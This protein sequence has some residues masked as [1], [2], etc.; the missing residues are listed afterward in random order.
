M[1]RDDV[2]LVGAG[3]AHLV[4]L[5]RFAM[6]PLAPQARLTLVVP[7]A[8]E[9]YSGAVPAVMAGRWRR[10]QASVDLAWLA[11]AAGARLV[12]AEAVGLDRT[13]RLLHLGDRPPL[14][15]DWLS[16]CP[17]ADPLLV[18][19]AAEHA[20]PLKPLRRL[21]DAWETAAR[22]GLRVAVVGGGAAG[23][24]A[25]LAAR[26]RGAAVT[27]V[28]PE[29][30]LSSL[31][32]A[33]RLARRALAKAGVTVLKGRATEL[34]PHELLL[35]DGGAVPF[36]LCLWAAG[37]RPPAWLADS[38]LARDEKG[39]FVAEP[40]LRARSE[41]RIFLAGDVAS[42]EGAP[43]PRNG[44]HSVRAGVPLAE[45]LRAAL[46]GRA[47]RP[48]RPQRRHLALLQA[49]D[50]AIA[51][52]GGWAAAGRWAL[53]WKDRIDRNWVESFRALPSMTA[54]PAAEMRCEGCGAK[55][56]AAALSGALARLGGLPGGA[57]DDAAA[58]PRLGAAV[59]S[60]D[61]FRPPTDDPWVAGR[62][63]AAH[64]LGD[65]AAM[66]AEPRA[67]LAVVALPHAGSRVTEEELFQL[68][69]GARSVLG[70]A[71]ARLLGGHSAEA[72]APLI[73]FA[74]TGEGAAA[75]LHRS[76]LRAGQV[77]LLTKPLGTGA[78]L[79]GAMRGPG[80]GRFLA[81]TL[82]AMQEDPMPAARILG[83]HG[84]TAAADVTGFGLAG[85]LLEMLEASACGAELDPWAVRAL[86]GA[87]EALGAGIRSTAYPANLEAV[88]GRLDGCETL[89]QARLD[90]L[91]DPQT[92]GGLLAGLHAERAAGCVAALRRAGLA[93]ALIGRCVAGPP[94]IRLQ[95]GL[96]L[97]RLPEDERGDRND[98]AG[99]GKPL[100]AAAG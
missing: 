28:A 14:R 82:A 44:V 6:R 95:P 96:P 93:A 39:W 30:P 41:A 47:L 75:P 19:G 18:A 73:G 27:L 11:R 2:I 45:N 81:A 68:L 76:R 26:A 60:V 69:H 74:V 5:R 15:W 12:L 90:L 34:R 3:A 63:A 85:H 77:L 72:A 32:A 84:A 83:A 48:F 43:R 57:A 49:G 37:A 87:L 86:P 79:A 67:A 8:D 42:I 23:V 33:A 7:E 20:V 10:D 64:A 56:P 17:G 99:P 80:F 66:G 9:P 78:V 98:P 31:G 53:R 35:A 51:A 29:S 16:L 94:R 88:Q 24:E 22:P 13:A 40:T 52:W 92:S 89:P 91:L 70:R 61:F 59:Q 4:A 1:V 25:A 65:L 36:E 100:P 58:L 46:E 62:I 55:L 50:G 38:G 71:G 21:L 97:S 54:M